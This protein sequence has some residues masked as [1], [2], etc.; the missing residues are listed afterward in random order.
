[1]W[2]SVTRYGPRCGGKGISICLSIMNG[3]KTSNFALYSLVYTVSVDSGE[4]ADTG[5]ATASHGH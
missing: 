4:H 2:R 3:N 5:C 1:M